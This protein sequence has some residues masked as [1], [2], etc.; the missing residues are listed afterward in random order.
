MG[1]L[2]VGPGFK[3]WD[4]WVRA[5]SQTLRSLGERQESNLR[6]F[7]YGQE[8]KPWDPWVRAMR[9][10]T[11]RSLGVGQEPSQAKY[12]CT[13]CSPYSL[14]DLIAVAFTVQ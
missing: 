14:W 3:P 1:S 13:K 4:P 8:V 6:I 11:R 12:R 10:Q 5:R 7:E 9:S 2:G